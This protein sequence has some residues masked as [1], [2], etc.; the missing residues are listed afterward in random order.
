MLHK[1]SLA[2]EVVEVAALVVDCSSTVDGLW[3]TNL[4][5]PVIGAN[6]IISEI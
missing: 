1:P 4:A 3:C 5:S 6:R 2:M